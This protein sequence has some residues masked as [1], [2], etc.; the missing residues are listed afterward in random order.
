MLLYYYCFYEDD[1]AHAED[2]T[3]QPDPDF[4]HLGFL[5]S[6]VTGGTDLNRKE[7]FAHLTFLRFLRTSVRT[8]FKFAINCSLIHWIYPY[9]FHSFAI[10]EDDDYEANSQKTSW[11]NLFGSKPKKKLKRGHSFFVEMEIGSEA[12]E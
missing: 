5:S 3:D 8:L 4:D 7:R 11:W 10:T 12:F 6:M 9:T 1:H 2:H